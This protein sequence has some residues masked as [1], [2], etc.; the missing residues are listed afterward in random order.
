MVEIAVSAEPDDERPKPPRPGSIEATVRGCI[1][2][3]L[4]NGYGTGY[5]GNTNVFVYN[6]E[7]PLHGW[8]NKPKHGARDE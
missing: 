1:C 8:E 7:C 5:L 3:R 2:P 4:E 6:G